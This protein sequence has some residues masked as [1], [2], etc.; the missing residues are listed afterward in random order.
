[1][2]QLV[3]PCIDHIYTVRLSPV[4][5]SVF[6][7]LQVCISD[8]PSTAT[9]ALA[10]LYATKGRQL[11]AIAG[12]VRSTRAFPGLNLVVRTR[13]RVRLKML[14]PTS[15]ASLNFHTGYS[16]LEQRSENVTMMSAAVVDGSMLFC[17]QR[18]TSSKAGA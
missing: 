12:L 7:S 11:G 8:A 16:N 10:R 17:E 9:I 15:P 13:P 1:M 5:N 18:L 4:L 6:H 14:R 2:Y 3:P